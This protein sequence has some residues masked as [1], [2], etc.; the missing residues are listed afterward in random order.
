MIRSDSCTSSGA[1]FSLFY[2]VQ[3]LFH[4]QLLLAHDALRP[5]SISTHLRLNLQAHLHLNSSLSSLLDYFI[6]LIYIQLADFFTSAHLYST[7]TKSLT[8]SHQFTIINMIY[9]HFVQIV[10]SILSSLLSINF[11]VFDLPAPESSGRL[12][13]NRPPPSPPVFPRLRS[14]TFLFDNSS[15]P[16]PPQPPHRLPFCWRI[17]P[18]RHP[19]RPSP[20][21][22]PRWSRFFI[23]YTL[24]SLSNWC[25]SGLGFSP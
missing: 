12:S 9:L 10:I 17:S 3:A 2:M 15:P 11:P 19:L 14:K 24:A 8:S 20:T 23:S 22:R 13:W 25:K 5:P 7:T 4:P 16:P 1:L 21:F 6:L 18:L